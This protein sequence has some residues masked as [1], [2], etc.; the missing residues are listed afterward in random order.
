[1]YVIQ[2]MIHH[3]LQKVNFKQKVEIY[4]NSTSSKEKENKFLEFS[5]KYWYVYLI[6]ITL[7][8]G[9][10]IMIIRKRKRGSIK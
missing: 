9:L 2:I 6:P 1:M 10:V 8:V 4:K 5:K 7:I 3:K